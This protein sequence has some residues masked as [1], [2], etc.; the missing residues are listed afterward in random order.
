MIIFTKDEL[1][2][3]TI[4]FIVLT[5]CFSIATSGLNPHAFVSALPIVIVGVAIGSLVHE[6]GHK[7]V[8]MN[9][10]CDAEFKLWPLGLLVA[11]VTSFFGVVFASPGSTQVS[12]DHVSDEINGRISIAGPLANMMLAL[13]FIAIAIL[14]YPLKSHWVVFDLIFL[15]STIGFS[16]NS[17]LATFNL[18]PIYS[19]DGTKVLKWSAKI[20]IVAIVVSGIMML[21]SISIGPEN[22]VQL[23][24]GI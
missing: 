19:L 22:M 7:Y 3:L 16:V 17:F 6:L 10:G 15:I 9:H 20:W 23:A 13:V 8:A 5:I 18:F 24:M 14:M 4:S 2:D 1:R 21:I 11:F 12:S